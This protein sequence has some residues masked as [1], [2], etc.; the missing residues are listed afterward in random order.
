MFRRVPRVRQRDENDCGPACLAS[1]AAHY[2]CKLPVSRLRQYAFTDRGGTNILGMV[3]A[4]LRA[5]FDAKGV[6]GPFESL[7]RVPRPFIAHTTTNLGAHHFV[8]VYGITKRCV[9]LMDPVD[10]AV[11]KVSHDA[12]RNR[13]TSVLILL[14][15]SDR[16]RVR[17]E[18]RS[19][20]GSFVS[21]VRPH[22][23]VLAEALVGA[24]AYTVLGLSTAV[25]VQKISESRG[26]AIFW[27]CPPAA[28]DDLTDR[29]WV[30]CR[31]LRVGE[32]ALDGLGDG[33]T[34]PTRDAVA[35]CLDLA[36]HG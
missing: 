15:P 31:D 10:G 35:D 14:V 1:I 8:V 26:C 2:G 21:L 11:H 16:F 4:A 3:D 24:I 7:F 20:V 36:G 29:C 6:K 9:F 17:D 5:G 30:S 32:R 25:Y 12:F 23:S 28:L 19:V 18:R 22:R 13:W 34:Q 33:E 27:R